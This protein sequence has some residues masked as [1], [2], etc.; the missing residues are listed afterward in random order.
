ML[1]K[2]NG[3]ARA[4]FIGWVLILAPASFA[5]EKIMTAEDVVRRGEQLRHTIPE[6]PWRTSPAIEV[7]P[8]GEGLFNY[9][10]PVYELANPAGIL[11]A[12]TKDGNLYIRAE[13]EESH[14]ILSR[15]EGEWHWSV[16]GAKWSP[17][18]RLL[19]IKMI[20]YAGVPTI[21]IVRL[22]DGQSFI[23]HKPYVRVGERAWR[24]KIYIVNIG[25]GDVRGLEYEGSKPYTNIRAFSEDGKRLYLLQTDRF[26]RH[27]DLLE[28]D[29][30]NGEVRHRFSE[31]G[32]SGTFWW[33]LGLGY[34]R[35]VDD[36][37]FAVPL[38]DNGFLWLSERSGFAHIYRYSA[39]NKLLISLTESKT[40]GHVERI[41]K[42]DE[43]NRHV[44]AVMRGTEPDLYD[45]ALY[46]FHL[47]TGEALR[48]TGGPE[49]WH[50]DFAPDMKRVR[51]ERV[52][53]PDIWSVEE[54][55]TD[56]SSP[57]VTWQAEQDFL[58][59]FGWQPHLEYNFAADG[60]TPLRSLILKPG[61]FDP[62]KSYPVIEG[63]YGGPNAPTIHNAGPLPYL[64][65]NQE[66]ANLG[67]IVVR[68]DGRGSPGRGRD[69]R[70]FSSGR[71]GQVEMA[72]HAYVLRQLGKKYPWM[73]MDRVGIMGHSLGG[74]YSLRATLQFPDLYKAAVLLAGVTDISTSRI[75]MEAFMGCL[76]GDCPNAYAAGDNTNKI[77]ELSAPLLIIF[78]TG[79][80]G[81]PVEEV[82]RLISELDKHRKP[83]QALRL[84]GATHTSIFTRETL[85]RIGQYWHELFLEE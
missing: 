60:T 4:A 34:D 80:D 38:A 83:Y 70:N 7:K 59:E 73:D 2:T 12:G 9:W 32:P 13:S 6:N 63:T 48:L 79:D 41:V 78:G 39:D 66:I 85:G 71:L 52:G 51:F 29:L 19:A 17:D 47:D 22:E 55:G 68:T 20:N 81:V 10:R 56:G 27:L 40:A 77:A 43:V 42:V 25:T 15:R 62:S 82:E 35:I 33:L 53:F 76:P 46:R 31:K 18:G 3:L 28:V 74:Y 65:E 75:Y 37:K 50:I 84:E 61:D 72:D 57:I 44:Y 5:Q 69:F 21:P 45:Q 24:Q 8:V 1:K 14:R 67:F 64:L 11:A 16:D 30:A 49:L 23:T 58:Q 54:I 26:A 36:K